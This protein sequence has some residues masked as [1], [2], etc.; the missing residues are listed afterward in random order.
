M[1]DDQREEPHMK[2]WNVIVSIYQDGFKR[3]LRALR[4]LGSVERSPYH[5]AL[6][7]W[8]S[9]DDFQ[10]ILGLWASA[11][12]IVFVTEGPQRDAAI[13]KQNSPT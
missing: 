2:N 6:S 1:S 12:A 11:Q 5:K 4:E 3:A 9:I 13:D 8:R 7:H 10:G